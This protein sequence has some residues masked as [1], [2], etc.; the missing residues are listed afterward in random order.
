MIGQQ[1]VYYAM[2]LLFLVFYSIYAW[3]RCSLND[4]QR[5][6]LIVSTILYIVV[7]GII[8]ARMLYDPLLQQNISIS[9]MLYVNWYYWTYV[10]TNQINTNQFGT[11]IYG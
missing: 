2:T 1:L 3:K 5:M 7:F 8:G 11:I 6:E 4:Y 10:T 9:S